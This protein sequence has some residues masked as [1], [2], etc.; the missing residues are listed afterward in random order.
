MLTYLNGLPRCFL[1]DSG[2][3]VTFVSKQAYYKIPKRYRPP[4]KRSSNV[5]TMADGE[6][7][8]NILGGVSMPV[9]VHNKTFAFPMVVADLDVDGLWGMDFLK[10]FKCDIKLSSMTFAFDGHE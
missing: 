9:T 4:L 7:K 5:I 2:S 6:S 10:K 3:Q 1:I 8:L